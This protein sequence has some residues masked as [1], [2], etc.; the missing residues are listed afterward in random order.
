MPS[1]G[2]Y[3]EMALREKDRK[4][5]LEVEKVDLEATVAAQILEIAEKDETIRD[6]EDQI[7]NPE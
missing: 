1:P 5:Q 2:Q 7:N 3:K 6:L 4:E